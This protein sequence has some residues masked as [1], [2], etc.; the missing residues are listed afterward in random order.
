MLVREL[1]AEL[2]KHNPDLPVKIHPESELFLDVDLT[3]YGDVGQI[4]ENKFFLN[5]MDIY[6]EDEEEFK[7][8]CEMYYNPEIDKFPKFEEYFEKSKKNADTIHALFIKAVV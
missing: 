5:N 6:Y 3:A 7:D 1:I 4:Q 8:T 2:Q